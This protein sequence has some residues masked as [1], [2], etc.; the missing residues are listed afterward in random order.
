MNTACVNCIV[1][2]VSEE[3]DV[4]SLFTNTSGTAM[5]G[6]LFKLVNEEYPQWFRFTSSDFKTPKLWPKLEIYYTL[7]I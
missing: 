6:M 5:Y 4:T 7:P 2:P 3:I 1:P